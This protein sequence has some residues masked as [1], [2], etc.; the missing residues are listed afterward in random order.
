M[1]V[2]VP[3][4]S[5]RMCIYWLDTNIVRILLCPGVLSN[6]PDKLRKLYV[7]VAF[8]VDFLRKIA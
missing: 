3:F 5:A 6:F 7:K 8:V 4:E 2:Q 1:L